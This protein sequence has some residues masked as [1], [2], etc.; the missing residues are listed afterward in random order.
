V[1]LID[2]AKFSMTRSVPRIYS[3]HLRHSALWVF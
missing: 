2:L 3:L 1:T